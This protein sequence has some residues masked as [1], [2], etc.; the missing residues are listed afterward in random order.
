[1]A[2]NSEAILAHNAEFD[3][4]WF[5]EELLG[6]PWACSMD[7]EWPRPSPGKSLTAIALAH[8]VGVTRAHRAIDDVMT[9]A[10]L[11]ERAVELGASLETL[12]KRALR[13]KVRVV[14]S[15]PRHRNPELKAAGFRWDPER[16]QWWK[17]CFV[18]EVA[19]LP[20]D[21]REAP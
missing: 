16:T 20:F 7:I 6:V 9:L 21:V 14:A 5:G 1:M 3:R 12:I 17:K 8:G 13:P 18:D 15:L 11:L 19:T 2:A 4:Q 10:S